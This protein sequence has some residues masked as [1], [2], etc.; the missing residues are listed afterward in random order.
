MKIYTGSEDCGMTFLARGTE[1]SKDDI[2]VETYGTIDEL[3][4]FVGLLSSYVK[5]PFLQEIQSKLFKIGGYF[6]DEIANASEVSADEISALEI[7]ID[8]IESQLE[9]LHSFI[10]PR[11]NQ[12]V[13]LSL[14][15]RTICRKAERRM[16]A[17]RNAIGIEI[18]MDSAPFIYINRLSDYFF[19]LPRIENLK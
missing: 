10:L 8:S 12:A 19:V 3:N 5:E 15:C 13:G 9:P 7:S 17:L 1:V 14:V 2:R 16:M 11:G 18:E 4:S 6:A